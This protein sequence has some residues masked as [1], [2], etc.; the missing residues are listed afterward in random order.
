VE[1]KPINIDNPILD[2][3][4]HLAELAI[5]GLILHDNGIILGVNLTVEKFTGIPKEALIGSHI[6]KL[7]PQKA[8]KEIQKKI[9]EKPKEPYEINILGRDGVIRWGLVRAKS[10]FIEGRNLRIASIVDITSLKKSEFQLLESK[11]RNQL[12][13][14][15]INAGIWEYDFKKKLETWS[16]KFFELLGY[17]PGDIKASESSFNQ[18]THPEDIIRLND[19]YQ[20]HLSEGKSFKVEVRLKT[21]NDGYKWFISSGEASFEKNGSPL[22]MAGS[23]I[24]IDERKRAETA[25]KESETKLR[26]AQKLARI[27]SFEFDFV[28][29]V[30]KGSDLFLEMTGLPGDRGIQ[31]SEISNMVLP[32]ERREFKKNILAKIKNGMQ[33]SYDFRIR[34]QDNKIKYLHAL[35]YPIPNASGKMCKAVGVVQ[36]ISKRKESEKK[37]SSQNEELKKLNRE[38]DELL[39]SSS[40]DLRSPIASALGLVELIKSPNISEPDQAK[41]LDLLEDTLLKLNGFTKEIMDFFKSLRSEKVLKPINF[42]SLFEEVRET[43]KFSPDAGKIE[44]FISV[45]QEGEFENDARRIK[46]VISN[47]VSNAVKYHDPKKEN[48]YVRMEARVTEKRVLIQITDNGMGIDEKFQDRIFD[49]FFV[50][51]D[52]NIGSGLGLYLVRETID[53]LKGSISFSSQ[54]RIGSEFKVTIPNLVYEQKV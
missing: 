24:N 2:H 4:N 41:Y 28:T 53:M 50:A 33:A 3:F 6:A 13:F 11:A 34:T 17:K 42:G 18:L 32:E 5:E 43:L 37:I 38:L 39:Y 22:Y 21:K 15:G 54:V 45:E 49:M 8:T 36:D 14:S 16:P 40:H 29:R 12:V 52:K 44:F 35:S 20:A 10:Y 19:S 48:P 26:E 1:T 46:N 47:L 51:T 9:E 27:G 30:V 7:V 23:I 25:L 31:L